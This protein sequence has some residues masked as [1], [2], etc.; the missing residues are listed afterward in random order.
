MG[1]RPDIAA[2]VA[3]ANEKALRNQ[4]SG[5]ESNEVSHEEPE[6]VKGETE[7]LEKPDDAQAQIDAK[8][9]KQQRLAEIQTQRSEDAKALLD[10]RQVLNAGRT[11]SKME[12][13]SEEDKAGFFEELNREDAPVRLEDA[14]GKRAEINKRSKESNS[15]KSKLNEMT[16]EE[17]QALVEKLQTELKT[18]QELENLIK[19]CA[20]EV[21]EVEAKHSYQE[22][23]EIER[24]KAAGLSI[25]AENISNSNNVDKPD[26]RRASEIVDQI[27]EKASELGIVDKGPS[28][29]NVDR[30]MIARHKVG[31]A[32]V[33]LHKGSYTPSEPV[34]I[35][36]SENSRKLYD[37][38]E[39][40]KKLTTPVSV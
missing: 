40:L 7:S 30:D 5:S 37:L 18:R 26:F 27:L 38:N 17:R 31:I 34:K 24:L 10:V 2:T 22:N 29:L 23:R 14:P 15:E 6:E 21:G 20:V 36:I 16:P 33:T 9:L 35:L 13:L 3:A 28:G 4:A 8:L 25:T 1:E 32:K 11:I 12:G 39:D 19:K